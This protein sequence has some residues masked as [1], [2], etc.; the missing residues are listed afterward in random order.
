MDSRAQIALIE[1]G[2]NRSNPSTRLPPSRSPR[3]SRSAIRAGELPTGTLLGN[4]MDFAKSLGFSRPTMRRA[5]EYLVDHGLIVRRQGIGTRVVQPK[6]HAASRTD[7]SLFDDLSRGHREQKTKVLITRSS[8][9]RL[10]G[11]GEGPRE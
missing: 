7:G 11:D 5:M 1:R 3:P 2:L 4:E 6:V 10:R 8:T 9:H